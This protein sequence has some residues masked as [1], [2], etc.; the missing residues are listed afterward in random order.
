MLTVMSDVNE[1]NDGSREFNAM[2]RV[3]R[4]FFAMRNGALAQ[5][6]AEYGG[7][8]YRINFGLNLPQLT[9]IAR[10]FLPG[11]RQYEDIVAEG[12]AGSATIGDGEFSLAD[13][14]RKLRDNRSTRESMLIAPMLFP[15]NSLKLAEAM[16]W[17]RNAPTPEVVDILCMKLLRNHAEAPSIAES[18]LAAPLSSMDVYAGMRLLLNLLQ[19]G[20]SDAP[21]VEAILQRTLGDDDIEPTPLTHTVLRQLRD[22]LSFM[23]EENVEEDA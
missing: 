5:Q 17:V 1:T 12:R 11:G 14:A 3:K 18:L 22:E 10:D 15:V 19:I 8:K 9:A 2:Q 23:S 13:F 7:K 21:E 20:K 4:R 6:M 16:D